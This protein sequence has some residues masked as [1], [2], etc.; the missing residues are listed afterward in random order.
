M[1]DELLS[2]FHKYLLD[3]TQP[4]QDKDELVYDV[5]AAYMLHLMNSGNVPQQYLDL[6]EEYLREEVWDIY[7]KKTYGYFN[8]Q[9]YRKKRSGTAC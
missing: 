8:L 9:E 4:H 7:H 3:M 1:Q 5:V 6:L 2:I